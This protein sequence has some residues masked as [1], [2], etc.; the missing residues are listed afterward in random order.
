MTS[1]DDGF[2]GHAFESRDGEQR[3][4]VLH[5]LG[6]RQDHGLRTPVPAVA[7]T[8]SLLEERFLVVDAVLLVQGS[9]VPEDPHINNAVRPITLEVFFD[10]VG[11]N[12]QVKPRWVR[13]TSGQQSLTCALEGAPTDL[14][15]GP[16]CFHDNH[17]NINSDHFICFL[18]YQRT[19]VARIISD[20]HRNKNMGH[21]AKEYFPGALMSNKTQ[22]EHVPELSSFG[23]FGP[24][25]RCA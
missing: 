21:A 5:Q 17:L 18:R 2:T 16:Q 12:R 4:H 14:Q 1:R 11:Y 6:C 25:I 23:T 9:E 20:Q 7:G 15:L 22:R 19:D 8:E 3:N 10:D 13:V 24:R